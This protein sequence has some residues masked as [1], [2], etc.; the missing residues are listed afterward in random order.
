M[1]KELLKA[2]GIEERVHLLPADFTKDN[3]GNGYD[4]V[5]SSDVFHAYRTNLPEILR[6]IRSSLKDCGILISK[7]WHLNDISQAPLRALLFD[8]TLSLSRVGTDFEL[9]TM[10][11]FISSLRDAGFFVEKSLTYIDSKVLLSL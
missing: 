8:L 4:V 6:K 11:E 9:F 2:S 1:T 7:H 10:G 3:I 5:L